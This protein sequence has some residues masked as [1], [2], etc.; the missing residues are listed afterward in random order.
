M[1]FQGEDLPIVLEKSRVRHSPICCTAV[2][3]NTNCSCA[4][5]NQTFLVRQYKREEWVIGFILFIRSPDQYHTVCLY[6]HNMLAQ[7]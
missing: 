2:M 6:C 7:F 5:M 1:A 4:F 3:R